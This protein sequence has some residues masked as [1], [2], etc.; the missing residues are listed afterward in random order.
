MTIPPCHLP[1]DSHSA[2]PI[3]RSGSW[4]RIGDARA[5]ELVA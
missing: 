5:A 3:R 1:A 2:P 4:E